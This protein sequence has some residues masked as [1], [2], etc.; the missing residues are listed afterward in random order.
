MN[1][2]PLMHAIRPTYCLVKKKKKK[3]KSF[4]RVGLGAFPVSVVTALFVS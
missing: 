1:G 4:N 2:M 3:K